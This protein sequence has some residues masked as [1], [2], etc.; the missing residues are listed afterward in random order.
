MVLENVDQIFLL[1]NSR[2][3]PERLNRLLPH[4]LERGIPK[5]K[6]TM[7]GPTW[8]DELTSEE[9]FQFYDPFCRKELPVFTFKARCLS[10]GEISLVMNFI[11]GAQEACRRGYKTVVFL[12]S[13]VFLRD[14]FIS[15]LDALIAQPVDWDYISLGEGVRTRPTN[16]DISQ[17]GPT[18]LYEPPHQ[19][20]YR[21]TDSMLF[22]VSYLQ[23]ILQT[24]RPF[25][26]CLDWELN[27]QNMHHKGISLW[28]DPPLVEQG[29]C[30]GRLETTLTS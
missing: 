26:E 16:C 19:F 3:E 29:T 14:D 27:I 11:W 23:R 21:C 30:C 25:R 8:G 7:S 20:V 22:K 10:R 17:F 18:K 9:I 28:A 24:M 12:E 5:D 2:R 13:D 15:R 4:L 6:I 1:A